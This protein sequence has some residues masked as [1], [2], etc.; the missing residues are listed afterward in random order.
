VNQR[1]ASARYYLFEDVL[2]EAQSFAPLRQQRPIAELTLLAGLVWAKEN[3]KG[4]C[5]TVRAIGKAPSSDYTSSGKRGV[6]GVIRLASK[7]QSL[8]GLLHELA[9]ALGHNDKLTHGP[10]FRQRANRL[11]KVYGGWNGVI[12]FDRT[13]ADYEHGV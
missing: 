13:K 8:G 2:W 5:P 6:A 10:A 7:H 3:G 1:K 4:P 11:Y 12:A 9:H